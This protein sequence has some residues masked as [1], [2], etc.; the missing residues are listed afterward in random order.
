MV[1]LVVPVVEAE[2][3]RVEDVTPSRRLGGMSRMGQP[4]A[5][6]IS[7]LVRAPAAAAAAVI[8]ARVAR[9]IRPDWLASASAAAAAVVS[10]MSEAMRAFA[11][12]QLGALEEGGRKETA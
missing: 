5:R 1:L 2:R 11:T 8:A 12:A 4:V 9:F 7:S 3:G 6:D 10:A